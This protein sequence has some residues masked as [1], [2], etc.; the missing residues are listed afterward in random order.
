MDIGN[1][2]PGQTPTPGLGSSSQSTTSSSHGGSDSYPDL[3]D[4]EYAAQWGQDWSTGDA[5]TSG[6]TDGELYGLQKG[7][8]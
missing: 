2:A 5:D 4:Y 3:N 7:K 1:I 8:D 6:S